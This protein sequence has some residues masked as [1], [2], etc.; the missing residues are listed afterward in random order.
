MQLTSQ[1]IQLFVKEVKK[2]EE[3]LKDC[4]W[5]ISKEMCSELRAIPFPS[6][7]LVDVCEKV[8]LILGQ[9]DQSFNSF[10]SLTK[11]F[12]LF[13]NLLNAAQQ[14]DFPENLA[15]S[16]MPIWKNQDNIQQKLLYISKCGCLLAKWIYLLI[17]INLKLDTI[18]SSQKREPELEKKIRDSKQICKNFENHLASLKEAEEEKRSGVNSN[19]EFASEEF[20]QKFTFIEDIEFKSKPQI[21][22]N[23]SFQNFI[24]FPNFQDDKLYDEKS[25]KIPEISIEN[26]NED[27]GCCKLRFFCF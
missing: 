18:K 24:Q 14:Q 7:T 23:F 25:L 12:S 5:K 26:E 13:K 19:A 3:E 8:M 22:E 15:Y 21:D 16:L 17:D 11:K 6:R 27:L 1:Q 10:K 20:T 4:N 9:K 2:V